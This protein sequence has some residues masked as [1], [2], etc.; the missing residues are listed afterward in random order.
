MTLDYILSNSVL[1]LKPSY[2]YILNNL[3]KNGLHQY[4]IGLGYYYKIKED[5]SLKLSYNQ[6]IITTIEKK[7]L[8][9]MVSFEYNQ[10]FNK[11]RGEL[12]IRWSNITNNPHFISF[13]QNFNLDN[14]SYLAIR[15]SQIYIQ[16]NKK[17]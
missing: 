10:K 6:Y 13:T 5:I 16:I 14:F 9:E 8:N 12:I 11:F 1:S 3:N 7:I 15:P 2:V 17:F 4:D